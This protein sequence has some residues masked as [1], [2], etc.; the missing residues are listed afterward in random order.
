MNVFKKFRRVQYLASNHAV[1]RCKKRTNILPSYARENIQ[2][3]CRNG[4]VL[5]EVDDY[6]Y[7]RFKDDEYDLFFP[8]I[9]WSENAWVV[10][11]TMKWEMVSHRLQNIIDNYH[12]NNFEV[13]A[14]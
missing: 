1:F 4:E 13:S 8:C 9:K 2:N 14:Y 7:I 6:R 12:L 10:K 3:F 5:L 11:T